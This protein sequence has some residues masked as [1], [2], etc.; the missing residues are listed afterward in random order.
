MDIS[1]RVME[2]EERAFAYTQDQQILQSSGCIGHLRVDMDSTGT[3]F[4]S[5]WD[6]YSPSLKDDA[7]KASFDK[8]IHE[9]RFNEDLGG[10]LTNRSSMSKFCHAIPESE[11]TDDGRN[12]GFRIDADEYAYMLRLNPDKGEYNAYIYAYDRE[13]LDAFLEVQQEREQKLTV[14]VVEPKKAPYR[15]TI[16]AGLESL[17]RE[18][19]G[20]IQAVSPFDDP[21]AIICDEESKL[22]GSE[23]NRALRDENGRIYDIVA[24]TFLV[25]G[26]G[27]ENFCSL[28]PSLMEKFATRFQTPEA[29]AR[30]GDQIISVPIAEKPK[31]RLEELIAT[32]QKNA[33]QQE[34]PIAPKE[35]G[36]ELEL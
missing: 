22:K 28:T 26:L 20:H 7:F 30:L 15:K 35:K 32:A 2:L 29:F 3:G 4:F 5:S 10:I 21:V 33:P 34:K 19:D 25:V 17:Q 1:I 11:I 16:D 6:T 24:G 23:L 12:F 9:L 18:V 13:K 31:T 27:E 8:L 14:L 36:M